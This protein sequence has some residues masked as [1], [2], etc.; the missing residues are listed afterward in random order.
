[1]RFDLRKA[2]LSAN[3]SGGM[4]S[5][6]GFDSEP[7]LVGDEDALIFIRGNSN[8]GEISDLN[9]TPEIG[10]PAMPPFTPLGAQ[11]RLIS[12]DYFPPIFLRN[13][14]VLK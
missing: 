7:R 14:W 9:R 11:V 5:R 8:L 3:E 1:M 4:Q 6:Q 2:S 10:E 12:S 13:P